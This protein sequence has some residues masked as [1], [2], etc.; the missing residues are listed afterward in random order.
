MNGG[1]APLLR[2]G[3]VEPSN[4]YLMRRFIQRCAGADDFRVVRA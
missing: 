3:T 4:I 1:D 2:R